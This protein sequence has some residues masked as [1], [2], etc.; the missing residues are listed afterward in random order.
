[1]MVSMKKGEDDRWYVDPSSMQ[2]NEEE[3]VTITPAPEPTPTLETSDNTPLYYNPEGGA[4]YHRDPNCRTINSKYLPLQGQFTYGELLQG[5][6][7]DLKACHICLA[8]ER[9][10]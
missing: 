9:P 5:A 6:H 1:M 7:S 8:P 2:T 10:K 4:K 3:V